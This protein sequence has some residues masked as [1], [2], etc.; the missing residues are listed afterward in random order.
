MATLNK[1]NSEKIS[2][3]STKKSVKKPVVKKQIVKKDEVKKDKPETKMDK[4]VFIVEEMW[5]D[6]C[7]GKVERKD[8]IKRLMDDAKLTKNG[9][10]TYFFNIK[11]KILE[12]ELN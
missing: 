9:A 4:A 10:A 6:Y 12:D 1:S 7:D 11:K 3:S 2:S 8:I 5:K